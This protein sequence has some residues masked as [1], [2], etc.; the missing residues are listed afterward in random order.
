VA[1]SAPSFALLMA[2]YL[3]FVLVWPTTR[4]THEACLRLYQNILLAAAGVVLLQLAASVA[5]QVRDL[6]NLERYVPSRLL[7]PGYNYWAPIRWGSDFI[8][9]NGLVFLE[10]S[11]AGIYLACALILELTV[12]HRIWRIALY[13]AALAGCMSG[14]G[15]FMLALAAPWILAQLPRRS[16]PL[17]I[18]LGAAGLAVVIYL[19]V[20]AT[21]LQ[22]VEEFGKPGSSAWSRFI[23][24]LYQMQTFAR[25]PMQ[26]VTG[27][28]PG[29]VSLFRSSPWPVTKLFGE[30]GALCAAAYFVLLLV[31]V[32]KAPNRGL[33]FALFVVLNFT[34]GYLL[35][36]LGMFLL[37]VLAGLPRPLDG[38]AEGQAESSAAAA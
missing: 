25:Q 3:P 28:G 31:A 11:F 33:A 27:A 30:Y 13:A 18:L 38:E 6:L 23:E 4:A 15:V 14:T 20:G 5:P 34:G 32:W 35:N 37:L 9:P 8:R 17:Q 36:P 29:N 12:F 21:L 19:K 2:I 24:P 7:L 10:P 26:A 1:F 16:L 22:R